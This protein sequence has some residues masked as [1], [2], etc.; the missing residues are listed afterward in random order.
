MREG[1]SASLLGIHTGP[2]TCTSSHLLRPPKAFVT[3]PHARIHVVNIDLGHGPNAP[4]P[5]VSCLIV[6]RNKTFLAYVEDPEPL[7]VP[8]DD[9]GPAQTRWI[10]GGTG[11]LWL[12]YVHG[13]RLVRL[14]APADDGPRYL[15]MYD[16]GAPR[17]PAS[18]VTPQ[19]EILMHQAHELLLD[20][21]FD[22]PVIF[23]LPCRV[24][25]KRE[26]FPYSGFM[27]DEDRLI[28]LKV[29]ACNITIAGLSNMFIS[30]TGMTKER[31]LMCSRC[32]Q[33]YR[34]GKSFHESAETR[35][36]MGA[37]SS[38]RAGF[39]SY[40]ICTYRFR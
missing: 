32:D 14:H 8:W 38:R 39:L 21:V 6:I 12:R 35:N 16:F 34:L 27:L 36:P 29:R 26:T 23:R 13:E 20:T 19:E 28:G 11:S 25:T 9:W 37:W 10:P 40:V 24:L 2:F 17:G 7:D 4:E 3:A 15:E 30:D 1:A 31:A 22:S 33:L 5:P 18:W